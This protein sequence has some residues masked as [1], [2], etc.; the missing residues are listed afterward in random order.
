MWN[1]M[2]DLRVITVSWGKSGRELYDFIVLKWVGELTISGN[3]NRKVHGGLCSFPPIN[4]SI[5]NVD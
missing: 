4:L 2:G 1:K 5:G 3:S